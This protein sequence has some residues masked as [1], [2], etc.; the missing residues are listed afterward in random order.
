MSDFQA[1]GTLSVRLETCH[2]VYRQLVFSLLS[3]RPRL[4]HDLYGY[5]RTCT[6]SLSSHNGRAKE[7]NPRQIVALILTF[8]QVQLGA[9]RQKGSPSDL[10]INCRGAD[11]PRMIDRTGL[12]AR[13]HVG[14]LRLRVIVRYNF[15]DDAGIF[16]CDVPTTLYPRLSVHNSV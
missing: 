7:T 2:A 9:C 12:R 13:G 3:L 5:H 11:S 10:R 14:C 1:F 8:P 15:H 6:N 4:V 16:P